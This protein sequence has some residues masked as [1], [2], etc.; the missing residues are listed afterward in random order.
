MVAV[1][2]A[3]PGGERV[4]PA[5]LGV[6]SAPDRGPLELGALRTGLRKPAGVVFLLVGAALLLWL[7]WPSEGRLLLAAGFAL[8]A[9]LDRVVSRR[10]LRDPDLSIDAPPQV[11][12]GLPVPALLA[13]RSG[14]YPLRIETLW[15][16]PTLTLA[17]DTPAPGLIELPASARGVV[18]AALVDLAVSGPLGLFETR[19]RARTWFRAPMDV[20]PAPLPHPLDWPPLRTIAFG[21]T[22]T[23]PQG[24][25]LFRA[26]RPYTPGDPRRMVHWKA[27][28]HHGELMVKE[29]DGTGI[30]AL[31]VV[32]ELHA[33][34]LAAEQAVARARYIVEEAR[35][36]HWQVQ[37]VTV[38]P[39]GIAAPPPVD[40]TGRSLVLSLPDTGTGATVTV[41]R[42]VRST[43]DLV[44]RLAA[45]TFGAPSAPRWR[46]ETVVLSEGPDRWL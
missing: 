6:P 9:L 8:A 42:R 26:V 34:G 23:A 19:R 29:S 3:P 39:V 43:S 27:T 41:A 35:A 5:P 30:V 14:R 20:A 40:D 24:H 22:E 18:R 7:P 13:A 25:D 21:L 45:A 46:G 31:R 38:E 11:T 44:H 2:S 12:A 4:G 17:V 16:W 37:L 33:P 32:L 28:A 1:P 10:A 15:M 36:R